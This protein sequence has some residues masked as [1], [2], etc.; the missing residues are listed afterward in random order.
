MWIEPSFQCLKEE[1][2]SRRY[3]LFLRSVKSFTYARDHWSIAPL[4]YFERAP[5]R[6]SANS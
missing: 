3:L 2:V 6:G 5:V 4:I 1:F